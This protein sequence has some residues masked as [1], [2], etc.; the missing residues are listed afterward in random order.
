M[1]CGVV[2][3]RDQSSPILP[4]FRRA[5]MPVDDYAYLILKVFVIMAPRTEKCLQKL[6]SR[7]QT[8]TVASLLD[9][10]VKAT[11]RAV[12]NMNKF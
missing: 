12:Y 8:E 4:P 5:T 2:S 7:F 10:T 11:D 9:E 3:L 6:N 1:T